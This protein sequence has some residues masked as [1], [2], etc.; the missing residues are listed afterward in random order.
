M[1]RALREFLQWR[2]GDF[3]HPGGSQ[4]AAGTDMDYFG[5]AG[6]RMHMMFNFQANQNLVL[7][8]GGRR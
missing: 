8:T 2:Q 5:N 4:C 1:L 6:D 3:D 7:C